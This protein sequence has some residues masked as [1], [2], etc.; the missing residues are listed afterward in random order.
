MAKIRAL[1]LTC[2]LGLPGMLVGFTVAYINARDAVA[3]QIATR[4]WADLT[5]VNDVYWLYG[6]AGYFVS[7]VVGEQILTRIKRRNAK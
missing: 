6:L 7:V 3:V 2:S 1:L 4:G 5:G